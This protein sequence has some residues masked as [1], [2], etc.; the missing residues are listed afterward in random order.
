MP[1]QTSI[2]LTGATERQVEELK[3]HGYGSLTDV[4]RVAI[5]RLHREAGIAAVDGHS[6]VVHNRQVYG[7]TARLESLAGCEGVTIN[8]EK[9]APL[10]GYEIVAG[11]AYRGR[12]P[13]IPF[14]L[15]DWETLPSDVPGTDGFYYQ[16][17]PPRA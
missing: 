12:L 2:Q 10:A 6:V 7:N 5:D 17:Q 1:R 14:R 11:P 9:Y 8:G 16:I 13:E 3:A 15:T 4:V